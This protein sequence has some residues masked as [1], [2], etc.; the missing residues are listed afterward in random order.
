[1]KYTISILLKA[2]ESYE[3]ERRDGG[4]A[5]RAYTPTLFSMFRCGEKY[6]AR[7]AIPDWCMPDFDDSGFEPVSLSRSPGGRLER[8]V[9]PPIRVKKELPGKQLAP[10]LFDFGEHGS[11]WVRIA[12]RGPAG[13][14]IVIRYAENLTEDGQH[15][16]QSN[17]VLPWDNKDMTHTDRY[18]LCGE[19]EETWEQLFSYHGFR[20]VE[21]TGAY[22][23]NGPH[24]LLGHAAGVRLFV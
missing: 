19:G 12:V 20:Y 2:E 16:D 3:P 7:L 14:E 6:D 24:R 22:D 8:S 4:A 18:I 5:P 10:G 15:V 13:S 21:I 11:G 23:G 17:M 1:M 9:C